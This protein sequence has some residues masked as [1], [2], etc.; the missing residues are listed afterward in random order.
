MEGFAKWLSILPREIEHLTM[1]E[2]LNKMFFDRSK[3]NLTFRQYFTL[4]SIK[5]LEYYYPKY[6]IGGEWPT[7]YQSGAAGKPRYPGACSS[8]VHS[9]YKCIPCGCGQ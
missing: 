9:L 8:L 2:L 1:N 5:Q 4:R 6:Q 7:G 3:N